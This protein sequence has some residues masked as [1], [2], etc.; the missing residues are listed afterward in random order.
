MPI[1]TIT[2]PTFVVGNTVPSQS[3][4]LTLIQWIWLVYGLGVVTMLTR[5]GLNLRSVFKLISRGQA[6]HKPAYTLIRFPDD[7]TPSFSFGGYMVLNHTDSLIEPDVL[8]RHEEAHIR[9]RH[10]VD[11]LF[12]EIVQAAF[13]FN[14]VLLLYKHALQEVH[15][16]LAD[17]TVL[18]TP[19]PDY[20]HQ[21]V[22]Y[23]LN[24]PVTALTTPFVS[25]STLKQRIIML[26]KPASNRHALLG[27]ALILPMAACLVMCTQSGQDQAQS[28][29]LPATQQAAPRKAVKVEGEVFTVVE[30]QPAFPGGMKQLGEYLSQNI[31]YPQTA[32]KANIEGKV[33]VNFVVTKTGEITDVNL[34]K[35]IGYGA[36][37]EAIRVVQNMPNWKPG[38]QNG[39]A[40]NV[41]Y[42][43]P[44]RFQSDEVIQ[45]K[46]ALESSGKDEAENEFSSSLL[47][48]KNFTLDG[49][50]ID[51]QLLLST[52]K[53]AKEDGVHIAFT[54]N[55]KAST[56]SFNHVD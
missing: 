23:A 39:Q 20:P 54:I 8:I 1:G 10:T 30:N 56:V 21:L 44:I 19:Q 6:E 38:T 45:K 33:F 47:S 35:G 17:R 28:A 29:I 46:L 12:M 24:M 11:V 48:Y 4:G 42:N 15:E 49:K 14:P 51:R 43:L 3:D 27:Y 22:A 5:L 34:L 32:L 9:Q 2:L 41:K 25:K 52:I 55:D 16:F 13:W 31:K 36:D 40:V 7:S 18:K 26:Q 37:E 50:P 53:K